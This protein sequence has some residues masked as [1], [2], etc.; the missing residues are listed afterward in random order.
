MSNRQF[1]KPKLGP[2]YSDLEILS[3][4]GDWSDNLN[5]NKNP[6]TR[7]ELDWTND[8]KKNNVI[9]VDE[10]ENI[11]THNKPNLLPMGSMIKNNAK[12]IVGAKLNKTN[13]PPATEFPVFDTS[14]ANQSFMFNNNIQHFSPN[15]KLASGTQISYS[16]ESLS[17]NNFPV[18]GT[19][20]PNSVIDVNSS[21][22]SDLDKEHV[23]KKNTPIEIDKFRK[24]KLNASDLDLLD[25]TASSAVNPAVPE[26]IDIDEFENGTIGL[27]PKHSIQNSTNISSISFH[28]MSEI[29]TDDTSN[30]TNIQSR[31]SSRELPNQKIRLLTQHAGMKNSDENTVANLNLPSNTKVKIPILL[32]KEQ[33]DVMAL[34]EKGFNIFY[35]GSAGTGKSVLLREIIKLLKKNYG[36][37]AVA[38]TASTGLAAC[39]IGGITVHSFAGIGLGK[40]DAKKLYQ[41]VRRSKKHKE[42]WEKINA[43]I[44]DEISML[45][46][47]LLD[48]LD[49]IAQKIR[50]NKRPFGGIQLIFCGDF[51]QLPPVSKDPD[52]PTRFAFEAALWS[53]GIDVT[54]MLQKVFRQ[55]GDTEFIDMLN[56]MRLGQIDQ[57]TETEFKKLSRPLPN[58]DIIPAELYSTRLE[59]DRANTSRLSKLPGIA[60]T[61][62]AIDGG[63][64]QDQEAKNRLL[65]N[66]LAPQVLQLKVGSQVM[67]IKNIDSTLVNGSLGKVI[68]FIDADT[69][70]FY[71][72]M[73]ENPDLAVEELEKYKSNPELLRERWNV[74]NSDND[75]VIRRKSA[76]DQFCR[77]DPDLSTHSINDNIFDFLVNADH[78]TTS[79]IDGIERKRRLINEIHKSSNRKKLPLVRFRTADLSTRTVLVEPEDWVIEDENEKPLV[80]RVQLPLMLAWSISIHKSQGQTLPKVKVDLRRIFEKGQAYVALSRAVS[81]DG[82]QVL[83][84]DKSRIQAHEKVLDF[85]ATLSSSEEA[86][87]KLEAK[88]KARNSLKLNFAPMNEGRKVGSKQGSFSFANKPQTSTGIAAM[89]QKRSNK[90]LGAKLTSP[91]AN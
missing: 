72:T 48:R 42:R 31:P 84:F 51:F 28:S 6:P 52:N 27:L 2:T 38:V 82:L 50:R 81:R 65:Q 77:V 46:G 67:M 83:N 47:D 25:T 4:E 73:V 90:R 23:P 64:L 21:F 56:K 17:Q 89:L 69:Y 33:E 30:N 53:E 66:F 29:K 18:L 11:N 78:N 55:Q 80:S 45:D 36:H 39:N 34:A 54:I 43:L 88:T 49:F 14:T 41:K 74:E 22:D 26:I 13:T 75:A 20:K 86:L 32:S 35:S 24:D 60:N 68:D 5:T 62:L 9:V 58:D 76:K 71:E 15:Q 37:D 85:Y 59:V 40:G 3:D 8:M 70:M 61:F 57:K 10:V 44:I 87:K 91:D 16:K 63:T 12:N 19:F 7:L 1:K 79:D